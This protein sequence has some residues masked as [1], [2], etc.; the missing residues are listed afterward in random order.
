M[1]RRTIGAS[2]AISWQSADSKDALTVRQYQIVR[3]CI[4]VAIYFLAEVRLLTDVALPENGEGFAALV[5]YVSPVGS[6][7]AVFGEELRAHTHIV[8]AG[9][10]PA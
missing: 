10:F 1:C 7:H 6:C 4:S 5:A 3:C 2:W 9:R 8:G